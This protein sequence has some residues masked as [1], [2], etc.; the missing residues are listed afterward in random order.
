MLGHGMKT[1]DISQELKCD[2]YSVA[3]SQ[4]TQVHADKGI[5]KVSARKMH[6][7]KSKPFFFKFNLFFINAWP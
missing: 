2:H 3:E 5:R 1:L 7:I 6:W 4:H